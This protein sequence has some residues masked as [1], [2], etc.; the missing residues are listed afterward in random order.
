[1]CILTHVLCLAWLQPCSVAACACA[2]ACCLSCACVYR[3]NSLICASNRAFAS[4]LSFSAPHKA[5]ST[6]TFSICCRQQHHSGTRRARATQ[7]AHVDT[8]KLADAWRCMLQLTSICFLLPVD[9]TPR[10]EQKHKH[11]SHMSREHDVSTSQART[12]VRTHKP[13]SN[14]CSSC[15]ASVLKRVL[16]HLQLLLQVCIRT[17]ER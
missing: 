10:S 11:T 9:E 7:L 15:D 17:H 16:E 8:A 14:T 3:S 6:T 5:H 12:C 1:M 13:L 4:T 2:C